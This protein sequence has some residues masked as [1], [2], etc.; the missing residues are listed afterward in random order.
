MRVEPR[1]LGSADAEEQ[2]FGTIPAFMSSWPWSDWIVDGAS[3]D[4]ALA[5]YML[6][7]VA[8]ALYSDDDGW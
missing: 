2:G 5:W 3:F 8:H 6:E 1:C 4:T 7:R